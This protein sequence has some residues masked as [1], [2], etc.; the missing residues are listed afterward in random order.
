M[1][2]LVD[3]YKALITSQHRLRPKY[4]A[5]VESFLQ[6]CEDIYATA[7]YL[8]D[9]F[10]LDLAVGAQEDVLGILVGASRELDWQP[11]TQPTATLND[12]DYRILLKARIAKNH[13]K[14]GIEDLQT[15]W[16]TLFD[17]DIV[18]IDNQDMT[19]E[20]QIRNVPSSVVHEM[21]YMGMI[22]PKPQSVGINYHFVR[23]LDSSVYFGGAPGTHWKTAVSTPYPG[24]ESIDIG[25]YFAG[26]WSTH[27][28]N[29]V[30]PAPP[31]GADADIHTYYAGAE[32]WHKKHSVR[33]AYAAGATAAVTAVQPLAP[34]I[35][36]R[37]QV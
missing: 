4:M 3:S 14:G 21:I 12:D 24:D 25:L 6:Y 5:T 30:N 31:T 11:H 34:Y 37:T 36:K 20:V 1:S 7:V 26:I 18:I 9:E 13:W 33:Q 28:K 19:I 15:I 10:D 29:L 23:S 27:R 8:D 22:V 17:E 2:G 32:S 16:R 35:H